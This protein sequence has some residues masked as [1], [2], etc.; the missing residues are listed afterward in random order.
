MSVLDFSEFKSLKDME[1]FLSSV[2][3]M[4]AA[5]PLHAGLVKA[6]KK[7]SDDP[8][9]RVFNRLELVLDDDMEPTRVHFCDHEGELL[10]ILDVKE[11]VVWQK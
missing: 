2:S 8:M 7:K 4:R 10:L 5:S 1:T 9:F 3:S 11:G 6:S